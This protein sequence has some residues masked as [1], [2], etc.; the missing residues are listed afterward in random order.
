ME[1]IEEYELKTTVRKALGAAPEGM[2]VGIS[3]YS[4]WLK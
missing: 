2:C 1:S 4:A 3:D